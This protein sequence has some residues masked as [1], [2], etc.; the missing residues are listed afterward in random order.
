MA[1]SKGRLAGTTR[2]TTVLELSRLLA[3]RTGLT[4]DEVRE[5]TPEVAACALSGARPV[6][7]EAINSPAAGAASQRN[8]RSPRRAGPT[9]MAVRSGDS[10]SGGPFG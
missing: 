2:L 3:S 6:T 9:A 8:R 7:K 5:R 4:E 1:D 10:I